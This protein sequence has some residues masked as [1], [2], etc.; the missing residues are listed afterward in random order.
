MIEFAPSPT[1]QNR[2]EQNRN[3]S[4]CLKNTDA[5][6]YCT[7]VF[8]NTSDLVRIL[9]FPCQPKKHLVCVIVRIS[10]YN[11]LYKGSS[12]CVRAAECLDKDSL[13]MQES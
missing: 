3:A 8:I 9:P 5:S 6:S 11:G 2:T 4:I 10:L 12:V 1:E 13:F 7:H